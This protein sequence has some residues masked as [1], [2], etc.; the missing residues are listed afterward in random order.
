MGG[1]KRRSDRIMFS[2]AIAIQGT[3]P[4]GQPFEAGGRTITLNRHGARIQVSR[5]LHTGG[6]VHIVNQE[7]FEDADFRVVG[8]V[9]PPTETVGEWGVECLDVKQNIWGIYFPP[10]APEAEARGLLECRRCH[11]IALTPLSLV[12]V[13][14]LE[15]AGILTKPC[16]ACGSATPQ[17]YPEARIEKE[18]QVF[19]AQAS[20]AEL[21]SADRRSSARTAIQ[22]PARLR[23]FYGNVESPLT[24]NLS[25]EGFCFTTEK[26]YHIG[27][28]VMVLCPYSPTGDKLESRARI[29]RAEPLAGTNRY[30]CGLR[31]EAAVA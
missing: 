15:T 20:E 30:L 26:K 23:D 17:G 18:F 10:P 14:V 16:P 1:E 9:S 25:K 2:I 4:Q 8:P 21:P 5:P 24:E 3:D 29:V 28:A 12:E 31:Y 19:Q 13:E 11:G 22:V 7:T 27:Q 6:T